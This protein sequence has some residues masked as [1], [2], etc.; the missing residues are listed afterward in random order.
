MLDP[1]IIVPAVLAVVAIAAVGVMAIILVKANGRDEDVPQ[2]PARVRSFTAPT[3]SYTKTTMK[4]TRPIAKAAA[5]P[6]RKRKR[7]DVDVSKAV[8]I[9]TEFGN[10]RSVAEHLG[11]SVTTAWRI[12]SKEGVVKPLSRLSKE[13][14]LQIQEA[15]AEGAESNR[16]IAARFGVSWGTIARI[17]KEG[18]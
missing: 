10:L 2:P 5:K 3:Y 16:E 8:D 7:L 15:L 14:K 17:A 11:I 4:T 6:G 12:L 18:V 1:D 9:Y 13:T